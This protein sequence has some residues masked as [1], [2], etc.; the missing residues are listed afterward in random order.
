MG[1]LHYQIGKCCKSCRFKDEAMRPDYSFEPVCDKHEDENIDLWGWC[2]LYEQR[3]L[4]TNPIT[5]EG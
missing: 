3:A 4:W 1:I 2:P 5:K